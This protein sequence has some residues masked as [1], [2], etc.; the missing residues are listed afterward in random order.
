VFAP[1]FHSYH[2][3]SSTIDR[4][5]LVMFYIHPVEQARWLQ[6]RGT[7]TPPYDAIRNV[8]EEK[9]ERYPLIEFGQDPL[10][11]K[12]ERAACLI[13]APRGRIIRNAD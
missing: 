3:F 7:D 10:V 9:L 5:V 2:G 1:H 4:E 11:R 12:R 8:I 13:N 6:V